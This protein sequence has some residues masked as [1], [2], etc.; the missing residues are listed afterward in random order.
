MNAPDPIVTASLY[1]DRALDDALAAVVAPFRSALPEAWGLWFVRYS[2]GG[3]H[4]KLRL[5]G[6]ADQA[7]AVR[8]Q[9]G[10]AVTAFL[11]TRAPG[12]DAAPRVSRPDAP[13]IDPE[14]EAQGERPDRALVWTQYRRSHVSL[15]PLPFLAD[16]P[17]TAR[18]T[19]ALARGSDLALEAL[20]SGL[21]AEALASLQ[22]RT[23][24]KALIAGL[25][26]LRFSLDRCCSYL[27]Y[28][29][30]WLVRFV[31][32]DAR[33]GDEMRARFGQQAGRALV[34]R[35]QLSAIAAERWNT[36]EAPRGDSAEERFG[37]SLAELIAHM[38]QFREIESVDPFTDDP[39]FPALFK[40]VHG[41]ANQLG[42][43]PVTEAFVHHLLLSA[44]ERPA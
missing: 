39:A 8:D 14:D 43:T 1:C 32:E 37:A 5:H 17:Y 11:E 20:C 27:A 29:R 41:L 31:S 12:A 40:A 18:M 4:L 22:Q 10:R 28:H 15:G 6:P 24:L 19:T 34:I 35:G 44:V 9:L 21:P 7:D 26:A 38:E 13:A 2:R 33:R 16:D 36:A 3:E 25:G 30:D 23:L 42:M